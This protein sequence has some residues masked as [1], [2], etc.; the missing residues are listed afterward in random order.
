MSE[1]ESRLGDLKLLCF[2]NGIT[3]HSV[4]HILVS[5]PELISLCL[6]IRVHKAADLRILYCA[7]FALRRKR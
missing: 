4:Y 6:F 2:C 1:L 5:H 7:P 3:A